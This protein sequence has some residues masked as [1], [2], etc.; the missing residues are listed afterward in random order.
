MS[1][2]VQTFGWYCTLLI[3][4]TLSTK[5]CHYLQHSQSILGQFRRTD[6]G[7]FTIM[8]T[9]HIRTVTPLRTLCQIH[10]EL[11]KPNMDTVQ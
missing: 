2:C 4:D 3:N 5:R 10:L 11:E 1:R 8:L 9:V 7:S 6:W